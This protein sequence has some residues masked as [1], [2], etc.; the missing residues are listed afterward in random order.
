MV[1]YNIQSNETGKYIDAGLSLTIQ[2]TGS[3]QVIKGVRDNVNLSNF[4]DF[5]EGNI[6][7]SLSTCLMGGAQV[8]T[9][10]TGLIQRWS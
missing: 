3:A 9:D 4:D 6:V 7:N 10:E 5:F 8:G 2:A 1:V